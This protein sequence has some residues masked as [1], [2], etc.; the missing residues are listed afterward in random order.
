MKNRKGFTIVELVI[1]IAVIGILAAVLIPTF[2]TVTRQ[3][4]LSSATSQ[5]KNATTAVNSAMNGTLTEGSVF[6]I[7]NDGD[8][9]AE[10]WFQ[11][12]KS[13]CAQMNINAANYPVGSNT[14]IVV[15]TENKT[16]TAYSVYVAADCFENA[17]V[18][19]TEAAA[20]KE[21][22]QKF[23]AN[24]ASR[25]EYNAKAGSAT[26]TDGSDLAENAKAQWIATVIVGENTYY[27][28]FNVYDNE[29]IQT[30]CVAFINLN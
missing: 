9:D 24:V 7:N 27:Y 3:A 17:K 14:T 30:T 23:L 16:A 28:V 13:A 8:F 15:E 22:V 6:A 21:A 12:E 2:T 5:A 1:V 18:N 19:A 25:G 4:R 20:N 29:D 26:F 11:W 10:Y